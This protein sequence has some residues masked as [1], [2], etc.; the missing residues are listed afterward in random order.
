MIFPDVT[1]MFSFCWCSRCLSPLT[2]PSPLAATTAVDGSSPSCTRAWYPTPFTA[3]DERNSLFLSHTLTEKI[4]CT[5]VSNELG[6]ML[7]KI[8][9]F[10]YCVIW[11]DQNKSRVTVYPQKNK[12]DSYPWKGR[13]REREKKKERKREREDKVNAVQRSSCSK[14]L[15]QVSRNTRAT[16]S[17]VRVRL[18]AGNIYRQMGRLIT[19]ILTLTNFNFIK[20]DSSL[21]LTSLAVANDGFWQK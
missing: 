1:K 15:S 5:L 3:T 9:V 17:L 10:F 13:E 19:A 20:D 2:V 8:D 18:F 4:S 16:D 11:L 14:M 12:C 21:L 7:K 6:S